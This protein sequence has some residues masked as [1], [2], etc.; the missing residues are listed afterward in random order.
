[1]NTLAG[2]DNNIQALKDIAASD[3]NESTKNIALQKFVNGAKGDEKGMFDKVFGERHPDLYIAGL[4]AVCLLI[5]GG[6]CSYLF[7][8]D[9]SAVKELWN[10]FTPALTLIIGYVLG[11]KKEK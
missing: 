1:M 4:I 8:S 9:V 7:R 3:L 2:K 10:I 11:N 6:L 5:I